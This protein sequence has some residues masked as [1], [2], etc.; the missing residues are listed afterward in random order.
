[1][2]SEFQ[3]LSMLLVPVVA[4]IA[5]AIILSALENHGL[6]ANVITNRYQDGQ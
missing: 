3:L 6:T 5:G 2:I 1:M 4:Y